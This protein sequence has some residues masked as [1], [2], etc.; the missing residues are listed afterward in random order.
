MI[1]I[2]LVDDEPLALE[3]LKS[4]IEKRED[5]RVIGAYTDALQA[6]K[7]SVNLKPDII[8]TDINM[9]FM[10]GINLLEHI[11]ME[12]LKTR[13]GKYGEGNLFLSL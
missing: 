4:L 11:R 6:M 7:E 9:P 5:Y 10:N 12:K 8:I 1:Q 3:Y 13:C 2:I